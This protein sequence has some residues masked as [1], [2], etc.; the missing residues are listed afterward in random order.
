MSATEIKQ[1]LLGSSRFDAQRSSLGTSA[2]ARLIELGRALAGV[3]SGA[4]TVGLC[5]QCWAP[6]N[7]YSSSP[8]Y[9]NVFCS[10]QCEREFVRAALASVTV[11]DCIRI[12]GRLETL[13]MGA[14]ASAFGRSSRNG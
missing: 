6:R 9:P 12:Q 2:A 10:E 8:E 4:S 14:K 7:S 5:S 1:Q 3:E 13:L 11:E